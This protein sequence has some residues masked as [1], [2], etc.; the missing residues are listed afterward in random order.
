MDRDARRSLLQDRCV[1][2]PNAGAATDEGKAVKRQQEIEVT[3]L[4]DYTCNVDYKTVAL[5]T[6]SIPL[7]VWK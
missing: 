4:R 5:L 2:F 7:R 1:P 3:C 6:N